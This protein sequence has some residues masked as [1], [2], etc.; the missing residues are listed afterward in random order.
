[1]NNNKR[2]VFIN[3]FLISLAT[4]I[5]K[6]LFFIITVI[7]AR[8]LSREHYGEYCTAL[9]IATFI[10]VF[11]NLNIGVSVVRAINLNKGYKNEYF[12]G[13]FIVKVILS[14][15]TY[16]ILL[17]SV[18]FTDYNINTIILTI[19][20]GL[21]RISGE[22]IVTIYS[23]YEADEKFKFTSVFVSIFSF[24]YLIG[25]LMA[26]LFNG[27]YF[28]I[29]NIRLLI[30]IAF[31]IIIFIPL[32]KHYQFIKNK[33]IIK[34]FLK[35]M[36][37]FSG[38]AVLTSMLLNI[39]IILV[40]LSHGTI[41]AG[42]YQN[43]F[44]FISAITFIP[45]NLIRVLTPFLYKYPF[46][47]YKDKFQ[48]AFNIYSKL[49]AS[50]SF[51]LLLIFYLYSS[52]II[53]LIFEN[54][55]SDSIPALKIFAFSI[56]FLFSIGQVIITTIDKQKINTMI[57][58]FTLFF[59]I[60][61]SYIMIKYFKEEGAALSFIF[62]F[63]MIY[64]LSHCYLIF[65]NYIRYSTIFFINI[66]FVLFCIAICLI[67]MY[68]LANL[69]FLVSWVINTILYLLMI[70]IFIVK[71]DDLRIIKEIFRFNNNSI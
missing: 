61:I 24:A 66:K 48:F 21:V 9:G 46:H 38:S 16:I 20:L 15:L 1:M 56:P 59:G 65:K 71:K 35:D 22:F 17:I 10:A 62:I 13:S 53:S 6:I 70:L 11:S 27:D 26:V 67:Q 43:A 23:Y 36:L 7:I 55:Y 49:F 39:G 40:P 63:L 32:K 14:I 42:I 37:P 33:I 45:N 19:I 25:T 58:G 3:T 64:I 51:Y 18:I 29:V 41:H 57:D 34:Q 8:Y 50:I 4:I 44:I 54:K 52:N 47:E 69:Y 28:T 31:L 30:T 5:E 12:T 2:K 68:F 60:I